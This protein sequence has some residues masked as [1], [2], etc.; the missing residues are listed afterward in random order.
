MRQLPLAAVVALVVLLAVT[1]VSV[2]ASASEGLAEDRV[3]F[4]RGERAEL[5]LR[6]VDAVAAYERSLTLAPDGA[7]AAR[8]RARLEYLSAR[9][10]EG[11]A[12]LADLDRVRRDESLARSRPAL[13]ALEARARAMPRGLVRQEALVFAAESERLRLGEPLRAA[14]LYA[15]AA[16][17]AAPGDP[18][19]RHAAREA[20]EAW[21]AAGE[22]A[23]AQA[24]VRE[25]GPRADRELA[26]RAARLA[27]R[28][29][30][31][32]AAL[33]V[34]AAFVA[35]VAD[36]IRRAG[37]AGRLPAIGEA[38]RRGARPVLA[39]AALLG[40]AGALLAH[41][42]EAGTGAPF[43]GLAIGVAVIALGGRAW[44]AASGRAS[45]VRG[46]V[47]AASVVAGAALVLEGLDP[48]Y[49]E[50]FGL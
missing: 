11:F 26:A 28:R 36:A 4:E 27:R 40:A 25:L 31:H 19:G 44:A 48:K 5:E 13:D 42:F 23:R 33:A 29:A 37:G 8:A 2:A 34:L 22:R 21:Y 20:F 15:E 41:R 12:A 17:E 6:Y 3:A 24:F 45:V 14:E 1:L 47:T 49:L 9:S 10:T 46:V 43:V 30:V 16:R 18:L 32:L 35:L 50:G 7:D 38:V 39:F